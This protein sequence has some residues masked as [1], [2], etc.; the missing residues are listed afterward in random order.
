MPTN[1]RWRRLSLRLVCYS[2]FLSFFSLTFFFHPFSFTVFLSRVSF[3]SVSFSL[4]LFQSYPG[5]DRTSF[6]FLGCNLFFC[7]Q[8]HRYF[9]FSSMSNNGAGDKGLIKEWIIVRPA[10]LTDGPLTKQYRAGI[11]FSKNRISLYSL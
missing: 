9:I 7:Y 4:F 1:I 11:L 10:L 8:T 6:C 3:S 2:F 5:Y